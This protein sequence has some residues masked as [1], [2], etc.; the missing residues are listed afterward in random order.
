MSRAGVTLGIATLLAA[1]FGFA[2]AAAAAA[3]PPCDTASPAA[4]VFDSLPKRVKSGHADRFG[5]ADSGAGAATVPGRIQVEIAD[6]HGHSVRT[7]RTQPGERGSELFELVLHLGDRRATVSARYVERGPGAASC[8]RMIA[9]DVLERR[10]IYFPSRCRN[11]TIRPRTVRVA[12]GDG[13][14]Q[15]RRM[16][17][18][19]W[20]ADAASGTG[21]A[22]YKDCVPYCGAGQFHTTAVAVRLSRPRLCERIGRYMYTRLSYHL[23]EPSRDGRRAFP[24]DRYPAKPAHD[25]P[26][27]GPDRPALFPTGEE[28]AS[29]TVFTLSGQSGASG[30]DYTIDL[31][32]KTAW[33]T[34]TKDRGIMVTPNPGTFHAVGIITET[35]GWALELWYSD[36]ASPGGLDGGDWKPAAAQDPTEQ[37]NKLKVRDAKHYLVW[38]ADTAGKTVRINEIQVFQ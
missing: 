33:T 25:E 21:L 13:N 30:A 14:F 27:T 18:R 22:S 4:V 19:D 24:C 29:A 1:T 26:S 5:F 15:L 11:A 2:S 38:I 32:A 10:R 7:A 35:P 37:R 16:H 6:R 3:P 36:V 23:S 8:T 12:C 17:W 9:Q 20:H 28:P 34:K 31:N